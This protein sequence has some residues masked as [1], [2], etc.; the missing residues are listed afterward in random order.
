MEDGLQVTEEEKNNWNWYDKSFYAIAEGAKEFNDAVDEGID[1]AVDW[2]LHQKQV[3]E[4]TE[5]YFD[6]VIELNPKEEEQDST[7]PYEEYVFA[8]IDGKEI[9]AVS[10]IPSQIGC[11]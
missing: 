7:E 3:Q 4:F 11:V 9:K 2:T 5:K 1:Y 10:Q 6:Y 8:V